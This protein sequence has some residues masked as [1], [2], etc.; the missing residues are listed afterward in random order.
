MSSAQVSPQPKTEFPFQ[1]AHIS[2]HFISLTT[3]IASPLECSPQLQQPSLIELKRK[4]CRSE[5]GC[6]T[7]GTRQSIY[8]ADA[9]DNG[10]G[11]KCEG[12]D[13]TEKVGSMAVNIE[14]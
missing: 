3:S 5:V 1:R 14:G 13:E 6:V 9:M 2:F 11:E 8:F 7:V 10:G 12:E 4:V